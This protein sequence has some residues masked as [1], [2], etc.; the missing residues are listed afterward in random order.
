MRRVTTGLAALAAVLLL[1][2][3]PAH[4][5]IYWADTQSQTIGRAGN[6]GSGANDAFIHTGQLPFA[7]A[8]DASHIYWVNQSSNSIG[9]ANIDG[10]EVNNS[11]ITG[12][13]QPSGVAVNASSI[14]WSTLPGPI[15]RANL[16][17]SNK[18]LAFISG[19][20]ES[21]GI[22]VDSG[23][24][25]WA[26]DGNLGQ[27][28]YI[29]RAGLNGSTVENHFVTIPGT[30]F[31]CGIAV[32]AANVYWTEPGFLGPNG[33]RIGRANKVTGSGADPNFIGD[34]NGPCGITEDSAQHLFWA[35]SAT[36]MIASANTDATN[37]KE[38][39]FPTGG[40]EVCGVA[41]DSLAPP[42]A[43]STPGSSSSPPSNAFS[44]GHLKLNKKTG[45]AT[46]PVIVP[47]AGAVTLNGKGLAARHLTAA[48]A[49][50]QKVL[51]K[52]KGKAKTKLE[53]TGK[54]KVKATVTFTPPGGAANAQTRA[55]T[56]KKTR[57]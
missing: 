5:F 18:S 47:G 6:D 39:L 42:P 16:D 12:I 54:V 8:V 9:R 41:I 33:T 17:G 13:T 57:R 31:P 50:T 21:C 20:S 24:I 48:A 46:L 45:T 35:N 2:V 23:H 55:V 37:V 14:F 25:Y 27:P 10:T 34:A 38:A 56:L 51:L 32:D 44:F 28:A 40:K 30:S 11:F 1:A 26:D 19:A 22:A 15:G 7:V 49:G 52:A 36:N 4:A 29:G 3:P 43:P 53:T